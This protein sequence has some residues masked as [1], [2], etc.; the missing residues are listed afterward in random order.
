MGNVNNTIAVDT[1]IEKEPFR[2][3]KTFFRGIVCVLFSILV[4][5][6]FYILLIKFSSSF[7]IMIMIDNY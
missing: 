5:V 6:P 7:N 3:K 1:I 4:I 2:I